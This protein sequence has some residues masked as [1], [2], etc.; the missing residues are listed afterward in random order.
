MKRESIAETTLRKQVK[1]LDAEIDSYIREID[2]RRYTIDTLHSLRL[3]LLNEIE[4]LREQRLA[5]SE[6]K[7]P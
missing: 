6:R 4:R 7:K 2:L 5:A 3:N 1:A